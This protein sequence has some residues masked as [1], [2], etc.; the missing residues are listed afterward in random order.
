MATY[1][2]FGPKFIPFNHEHQTLRNIRR[3]ELAEPFNC[4]RAGLDPSDPKSGK[5]LET[6]VDDEFKR[7]KK[8]HKNNLSYIAIDLAYVDVNAF[9]IQAFLQPKGEEALQ[10]LERGL[11]WG[12]SKMTPDI[13]ATIAYYD[14]ELSYYDRDLEHGRISDRVWSAVTSLA[15]DYEELRPLRARVVYAR[16][17]GD[18]KKGAIMRPPVE[19]I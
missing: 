16:M 8:I 7:W 13:E 10:A 17:Q 19:D 11:V 1:R 18:M 12:N 6:I 5:L 2:K 4:E 14:H 15:R 9:V 3:G